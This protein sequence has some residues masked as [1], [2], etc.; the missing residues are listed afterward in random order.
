MARRRFSQKTNK[1]ICFVCFFAFHSKQN[2]F[3]RLFVFWENVRQAN[4]AFCFIWPLYMKRS[5]KKTRKNRSTRKKCPNPLLSTATS[6]LHLVRKQPPND[7]DQTKKPHTMGWNKSWRSIFTF[8]FSQ[9]NTLFQTKPRLPFQD[10]DI[11]S[12]FFSYSDFT[13]TPHDGR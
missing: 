1:R 9:K 3:V 2:K 10:W 13:L 4:P 6:K 8:F 5:T 7:I 12:F 11:S